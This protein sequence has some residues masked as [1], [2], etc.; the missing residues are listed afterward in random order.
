MIKKI[1]H[2]ETLRLQQMQLREQKRKLEATI[3]ILKQLKFKYAKVQI[4]TYPGGDIFNLK[5]CA[6]T[7]SA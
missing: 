7:S 1:K 3:T 4:Y 5:L 2:I 6:G